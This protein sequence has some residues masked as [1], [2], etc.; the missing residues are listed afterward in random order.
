MVGT[1]LTTWPA[2]H[3]CVAHL[4]GLYQPPPRCPL[5]PYSKRRGRGAS[6][7]RA[8]LLAHRRRRLWSPQG[9]RQAD[10]ATQAAWRKARQVSAQANLAGRLQWR[11]GRTA[12]GGQRSRHCEERHSSNLAT[13]TRRMLLQQ[14]RMLQLLQQRFR[15]KGR[16]PRMLRTCMGGAC[17]QALPSGCVV[18]GTGAWD[19]A[20]TTTGRKTRTNY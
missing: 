16:K 4:S 9:D 18:A 11:D 3:G 8:A 7:K 13:V 1:L 12:S 5:P 14:S 20:G 19:V 17:C 15:L 10:P 6:G 2:V